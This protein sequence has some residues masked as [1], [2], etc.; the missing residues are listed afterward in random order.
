MPKQPV[1]G[2]QARF[3]GAAIAAVAA[4]LAV[5]AAPVVAHADPATVPVEGVVYSAEGSGPLIGAGVDLEFVDTTTLA[6]VATATSD[7]TSHYEV[8]LPLGDYAV[9]VTAAPSG[10]P[11]PAVVAPLAAPVH[12]DN[13]GG[14]FYDAPV[15]P[16]SGTLSGTLSYA[17]GTGVEPASGDVVDVF[18][19]ALDGTWTRIAS[20]ST[21]GDGGWQTGP[22]APGPYRLEFGQVSH[23]PLDC[24]PVDYEPVFWGPSP[25]VEG[26]TSVT[27]VAAADTG[28]LDQT[29]HPWPTL[30]GYAS[31]PV[32]GG[33]GMGVTIEAVDPDDPS[34]VIAQG[35]VLGTAG[36]YTIDRIP[37]ATPFVIRFSGFEVGVNLVDTYYPGTTDLASAQ[38]F[39]LGWGASENDIDGGP[40]QLAVSGTTPTM[41]GTVQVGVPVT[42]VPGAWQTGASLDYAWKADGTTVGTGPSYTPTPADAGSGLTVTVTGSLSGYAS[43][44]LTSAASTV[45]PGVLQTVQPVIVGTQ[46]FSQALI[47]E[48]GT[49]TPSGETFTYQWFADGTAISGKTG[50]V[51]DLTDPAYVGQRITVQVTGALAGYTS[52]SALSLPTEPIQ[53]GSATVREPDGVPRPGSTITVHAAGFEPGETVRV[54]LHSTPVLLG[55]TVAGSD[56]TIS[57]DVALPAGTAHGSHTIVA[58]GTT[59]GRVVTIALSVAETL[60]FTGTDPRPALA[61]AAALTGLGALVVA[62]AA[63]RRRN[64]RR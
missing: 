64:A 47:V 26:G 48:T 53:P 9:V 28:G 12:V 52:A 50:Q 42:A 32:S 6:V 24:P 56:G 1:I 36:E 16:D 18:W 54:E 25:N 60:A 29:M 37:A 10:F 59:S 41:S 7:D 4:M 15:S 11:V 3:G 21:D 13:P 8:M 46:Q 44:S 51:L 33:D 63:L 5:L 57:V 55:T 49:W 31:L 39:T 23:C 35:Q 40:N 45:L 34:T 58:T 30:S 27:V 38:V 61:A 62:S 22:L 20:A 2:R 17:T 43:T 19:Q 14:V